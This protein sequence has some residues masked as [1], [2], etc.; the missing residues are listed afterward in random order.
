M[1]N[2]FKDK[3]TAR[4]WRLEFSKRLPP[5]IQQT[6]LRKLE[7]IAAAVRIENLKVPPGNCLEQ[8]KGRRAGQWSIRINSQ[9]RVCF[10]WLDGAACDVE[11]TDYH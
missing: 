7:M 2:S 9:W 5:E 1:I 6:A 11:I 8:L 3:E 4:I 10:S